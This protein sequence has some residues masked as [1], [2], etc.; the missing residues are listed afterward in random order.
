MDYTIYIL[1]LISLL[2]LVMFFGLSLVM[3]VLEREL[4]P[5]NLKQALMEFAC[6][7]NRE[8]NPKGYRKMRFYFWGS[9]VSMIGFMAFLEFA[10]V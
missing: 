4:A 2:L 5:V 3:L 7:L 6:M 1:I 10:Y 8:K 9:I